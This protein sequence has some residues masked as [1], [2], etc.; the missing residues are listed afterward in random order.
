MRTLVVGLNE[1]G[2]QW[3]G[4]LGDACVSLV[5]SIQEVPIAS[6]DAVI[7]CVGNDHKY[8]V[9]RYALVNEKHALV[10]APLWVNKLAHLEE[11]QQIAAKNACVLYAAY[12]ARFEPD[13]THLQQSIVKK[14]IGEIY[15]C[16]I[17]HAAN[18]ESNS[19]GALIDLT[20]QLLSLLWDWFG[21][22]AVP[23]N[24][25]IVHKDAFGRHVI[26]ADFD[27]KCTFELEANFFAVNNSINVEIY[28]ARDT[29]RVT[30]FYDLMVPELRAAH[31]H[32]M[33]MCAQEHAS[34]DPS[35]DKWIYEELD[36]LSSEQTLLA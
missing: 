26:F 16:R 19:N 21:A 28:G 36:R 13:F 2:L 9:A 20:P 29:L 6:Y 32:F 15:H 7:I 14:Q 11:L 22:E 4:I 23:N 12:P 10:I 27:A 30:Y 33:Q 8:S 35:S 34:T 5:N 3:Q 31:A 17:T 1:Q 25:R 24:L 18:Q